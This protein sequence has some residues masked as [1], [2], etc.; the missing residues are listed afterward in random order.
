M[1]GLMGVAEL[2]VV[3]EWL[4]DVQGTVVVDTVVVMEGMVVV[5]LMGVAELTVVVEW[6]TAVEMTVVVVEPVVV[7]EGMVLVVVD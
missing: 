7:M 2:T 6:L 4:T 1:A 5:G 3:V